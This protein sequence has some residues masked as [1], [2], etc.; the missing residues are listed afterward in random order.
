MVSS[1]IFCINIV[2]VHPPAVVDH[3]HTHIHMKYSL[4]CN[5]TESPLSPNFH[6][7]STWAPDGSTYTLPIIYSRP[8]PRK[9]RSWPTPTTRTRDHN[10]TQQYGSDTQWHTTKNIQCVTYFC[11]IA[12]NQHTIHEIHIA[13]NKNNTQNKN[14]VTHN[15][16]LYIILNYFKIILFII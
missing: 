3:T 9:V 14:T 4:Q 12:D 1:T 7:N 5:L 6:V 10:Y 2:F 11:H 8:T 13:A 15:M 16:S